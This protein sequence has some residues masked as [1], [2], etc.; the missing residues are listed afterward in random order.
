M[1][2]SSLS[3]TLPNFEGIHGGLAK[4]SRNGK[5]LV[6]ILRYVSIPKL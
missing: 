2:P 4:I 5:V 3:T 6:H 1:V